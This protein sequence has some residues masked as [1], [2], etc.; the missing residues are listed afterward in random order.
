VSIESRWPLFIVVGAF[1]V[2]TVV[3]RVVEPQREAIG[4]PWLVP[5]LQ[6]LLLVALVAANPADVRRRAVWLRPLALTLIGALVVVVLTSDVV[7][8]VDL[9]RGNEVTK[10]AATLLTSGALVWM[11]TALVFGLLYWE[12]DSG[13]PL[14]RLEHRRAYPDFAFAQQLSPELAPPGWQPRYVDYLLL[15]LTTSTAFSP[16]DVMPMTP[17]AKLTMGLQSLISLTVIG[18][19]IARAVNVFE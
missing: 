19:V 11:G 4:P 9:V 17:W 7:L 6:V 12:L 13:G 16:T 2:T 3:L 1:I 5:G 15:G 14:A 18:L 8:I 10:D